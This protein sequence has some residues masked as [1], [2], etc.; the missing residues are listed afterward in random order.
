LAILFLIKL[1]KKGFEPSA[2]ESEFLGS[3]TNRL[4]TAMGS[5]PELLERKRLIDLHT[6]VATALLDHIKARKLDSLFESEEKLLT[7][8]GGQRARGIGT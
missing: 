7:G 6:N 5:L 2:D 1:P 4:Q 3:A 8:Q